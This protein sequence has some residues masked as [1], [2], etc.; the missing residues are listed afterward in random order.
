VEGV[1]V[2][3]SVNVGGSFELI[4]WQ[5][6]WMGQIAQARLIGKLTRVDDIYADEVRLGRNSKSERIFARTV[7]VEDG[8]TAEEITYTDELRGDLGR[9]H[10][11]KSPV[12]VSR[13]PEPPI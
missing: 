2:A 9:V 12:K 13:L 1:I 7:E 5:K 4:N 8:C 10:I 11:E 6:N 3:Q